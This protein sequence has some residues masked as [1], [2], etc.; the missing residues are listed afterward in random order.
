MDIDNYST[1][2][3]IS[4]LSPWMLLTDLGIGSALQNKISEKRSLSEDVSSVICYGLMLSLVVASI[5]VFIAALSSSTIS[6]IY[7]KNTITQSENNHNYILFISLVFFIGAS[8]GAVSQKVWFALHKGWVGNILLALGSI[9]SFI[10]INLFGLGDFQ[11]ILLGSLALFYSPTAITCLFSFWLLWKRIDKKQIHTALRGR[12]TVDLFKNGLSFW[13]FSIFAALVLQAD[14]L[15]LSQ[16][17]SNED[18]LLYSVMQKLFSIAVFVYAAVLQ[19]LWPRC[20]ELQIAGKYRLIGQITTWHLSI[21]CL[22][23]LFFTAFIYF[24]SSYVFSLFGV[25]DPPS[26]ELIVLFGIYNLLR[27]WTDTFG[28][29]MQS[30]N[31]LYPLWIL[32]PLQA[33]ITIC[34]QFVLSDFYGLRGIVLGLIIGYVVTVAAVC[35]VIVYRHLKSRA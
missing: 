11:N 24:F 28:M 23:A 6:S 34:L 7:L 31:I 30:M 8:L 29:L 13:I 1:Y 3:L 10:I 15:V 35:P 19:A 33:L 17:S 20:A 22:G 18:I 32:V 25:L 12:L 16:K 14:Y 4:S 5:F 2:V 26:A 27:I 21:G 9:I